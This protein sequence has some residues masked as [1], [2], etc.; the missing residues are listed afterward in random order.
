MKTKIVSSLFCI[1]AGLLLGSCASGLS[2]P[3]T[4]SPDHRTQ[5]ISQYPG[6]GGRKI[7]VTETR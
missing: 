1:V 3:Q 5:V 6:E 4:S 2:D 7:N